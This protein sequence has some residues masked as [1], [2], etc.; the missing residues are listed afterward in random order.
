MSDEE[1]KDDINQEHEEVKNE[2]DQDDSS[3]LGSFFEKVFSMQFKVISNCTPFFTILTL[4]ILCLI[5]FGIRIF[6][7][8][9]FESIIHEFDPWFN[10]RA[11]KYLNTNGRRA[12]T[13]WFDTKS[14]YP[15]GRYVGKTVFPGLMYTT[16]FV[17]N[18]LHYLL[19][20]ISMKDICV[21]TAPVFAMFT[22]IVLFLLGKEVSG[23]TQTGL[24]AALF[25]STNPSYLTRSVAGS[26]DN[27]AISI[28]LLLLTC[29]CFLRACKTG[30]MSFAFGS[31]LFYGYL[32]ASWGGYTFLIVLFPLFILFTVFIG[33]FDYQKY[34]A[35]SIFYCFSSALSL[36][37][38][39]IEFKT[40]TSGE[41]ALSHITFIVIQA[42]IIFRFIKS[43]FSSDLLRKMIRLCILFS[44]PVIVLVIS[45]ILLSNR[46]TLMPR[47]LTVLDPSYAS[48]YA[49][50][51]AS[52]SE[53]QPT[54]WASFFFDLQYM[55]MFAPLGIFFLLKDKTFQ[56]SFICLWLLS[57]LYFSSI[58]IR[59]MLV[60]TPAMCIASAVAVSR[61]LFY[62][63]DFFHNGSKMEVFF[64]KINLL[65]PSNK[66][67]K[68]TQ[69]KS[70]PSAKS[71]SFEGLSVL[72]LVIFCMLLKYMTHGTIV[73]S[74]I[75]SSPTV[76]MANR[77]YKTGEKRMVDDFRQ[78][79]SFLRQ[80][81]PPRSRIL[82]WWDYGYQIAGFSDRITIADNNTW[83]FTHIALVG[84]ALTAPEEEA[85]SIMDELDCEYVM[86]QFGGA[87]GFKGDDINK[88]PWI[89]KITGNEYPDV[90]E[91]RFFIDNN[92]YV[93][94]NISEPMKN[95][96]MYKLA[97]YRF[98]EMETS[99]GL[100]FDLSRRTVIG[101]KD[102][103][104]SHFEEVFTSDRWLVRIYKRKP[105]NQR[106]HLQFENPAIDA[107]IDEDE[108][109]FYMDEKESEDYEEDYF[110]L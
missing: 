46:L 36:L 38:Q 56:G 103:K 81:T 27:E 78:A 21:F 51:V 48:T 35:Y 86:V 43:S 96:L 79:Y 88:F 101:H 57:T 87:I 23:K 95:S 41:H 99:K 62:V 30:S 33:Q 31:G 42:V 59:L 16:V 77:N 60:L 98:W 47:V 44:L 74:E 100:G 92:N 104:L 85:Y 97:Y 73:A 20:P 50:I 37:T 17:K 52:V 10:F 89:V 40:W 5:A 12:F 64:F 69:K 76:V 26:Y 108:R 82:A 8:I 70:N 67:K 29:F 72:L 13:Y 106:L 66:K 63:S 4:I 75:Y 107:L 15:L 84:K 22:T 7:V 19:I 71:I 54:S 9:K 94:S 28:T 80:N 93:G 83:N 25:I 109:Q 24:L 110:Y 32:L 14:W 61:I 11:T 34:I 91:S 2:S 105:K 39:S 53:H 55:M 68:N 102:F 90:K 45:W 49:P 1:I 3:S 65:N 6:S 58:M 18:L